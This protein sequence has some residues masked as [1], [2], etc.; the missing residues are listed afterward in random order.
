MYTYAAEGD[1]LV[2]ANGLLER[3]QD[4]VLFPLMTLMMA[5]ALLFFLYGAYEFVLGANDDTARTKGKTHMLWGVV[6][7]LVM[8]SAY[9][10]I[11]IA[12]G[13]F[14]C[15]IDTPGGCGGI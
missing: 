10:L 1:H 3:I 5:L 9:A 2:A 8:V 14:G 11:R 4:A 15:D 13:T 6:G 7:M 12:A